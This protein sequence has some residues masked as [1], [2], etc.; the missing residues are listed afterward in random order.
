MLC[1]YD[2]IHLE[3]TL[4]AADPQ[5]RFPP[6]GD[7]DAWQAL[8]HDLGEHAV[9]ALITQAEDAVSDPIPPLPATLFLEV[10]RTGQREGYETPQSRRR[11]MLLDLV[12]GECLEDE[13]RF[14]DP[15]LDVAW[16]S[17]EASRLGGM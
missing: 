2:P 8:R 14:L 4:R 12:F 7:R 11:E 3:R 15:I 9:T 5:P 16:A 1:Q 17:C 6:I 13:G 10:H